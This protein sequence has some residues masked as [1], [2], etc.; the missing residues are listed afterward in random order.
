MELHSPMTLTT[1]QRKTEFAELYVNLNVIIN[2]FTQDITLLVYLCTCMLLSL[3]P[4]HLLLLSSFHGPVPINAADVAADWENV[5]SVHSLG[6]IFFFFFSG[7]DQLH[8][9]QLHPV[10]SSVHSQT[11]SLI[12][13]LG[14]NFLCFPDLGAV[15]LIFLNF[16]L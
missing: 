1:L 16:V 3:T 12:W 6:M 5:C 14:Q 2:V 13:L 9:P 7:V 15:L 4:L 8:F 11:L 10:A